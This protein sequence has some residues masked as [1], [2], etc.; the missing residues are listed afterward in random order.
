MIND[1]S[2]VDGLMTS[3]RQSPKMSAWREGVPLLPLLNTFP[4]MYAANC[5]RR[6]ERHSRTR[7]MQSMWKLLAPPSPKTWMRRRSRCVWALPGL[8]RNI[9]SS[10]CMRPLIPRFISSAVLG[11]TIRPLPVSYTHLDVY[12]RQA[13]GRTQKDSAQ[14]ECR[15]GDL[16][17]ETLLL[18]K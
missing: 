5:V 1:W 4:A 14:K 17:W 6:S 13:Q 3:S 12:K 2:S 11:S 10:L 16:I 9:S 15:K 8:T 7:F 18:R